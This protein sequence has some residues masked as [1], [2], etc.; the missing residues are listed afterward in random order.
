MILTVKYRLT[1]VCRN[2]TEALL[3]NPNLKVKIESKFVIVTKMGL[4][5]KEAV[6]FRAKVN[7]NIFNAITNLFYFILNR[8]NQCISKHDK[9]GIFI[10]ME[11]H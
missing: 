6:Q 2:F 11:F 4:N 7:K 9:N 3:C 10:D 5:F 8:E 1:K